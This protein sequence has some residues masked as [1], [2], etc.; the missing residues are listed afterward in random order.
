MDKDPL[1]IKA[2]NAIVLVK[3]RQREAAAA[4]E[5][6]REQVRQHP[7]SAPLQYYLAQ[8]LESAGHRGEA[9]KAYAAASSGSIAFTPA[10]LALVRLDMAEGNTSE[11]RHGAERLLAQ[12]PGNIQALL[13]GARLA[14]AAGDY[15][16]AI[17]DYRKILDRDSS[18]ALAHNGLAWLLAEYANRLDEAMQHAQQANEEAPENASFSD[19]LGWI[20]Y[21]KGLYPASLTYL[22]AAVAK[23]PNAPH[24]Y[25]LAMAYRQSGYESEAR[26]MLDAALKSDPTMQDAIAAKKLWSEAVRLP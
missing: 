11:A 23:E 20:L 5:F 3:L 25:H 26:R 2:V 13:L 12:E 9:R 21:R 6:V 16:A 4:L 8:F 19:T 1:N 10:L 24:Q 18:N 17:A 7:E 22:K 14:V 15:S